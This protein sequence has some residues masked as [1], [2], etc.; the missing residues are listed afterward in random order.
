LVFL[1]VGE[2]AQ[3]GGLPSTLDLDMD[4]QGLDVFEKPLVFGWSFFLPVDD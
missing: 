2:L 1:Q 3:G 4:Q